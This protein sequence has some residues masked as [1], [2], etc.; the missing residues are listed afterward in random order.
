MSPRHEVDARTKLG[1]LRFLAVDNATLQATADEMAIPYQTVFDIASGYG[2]PEVDRMLRA[3]DHLQTV[4]DGHNDIPTPK[5][6]APR[7]DLSVARQPAP[8]ALAPPPVAPRVA[9]TSASVTELL[10]Q[11]F[12]SDHTRT[13]NL[14]TKISGLL[15]DLTARL[16]DETAER[17]AKTAAAAEKA[18]NAK[19]IAELEAEL[20]RLKGKPAPAAKG[21]HTTPAAGR[22]DSAQI[23]VWATANSVDCPAVGRVPNRVRE[24]YDNAHPA[25]QSA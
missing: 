10:H 17:Q 12:E 23:R 9:S 11:A 5:G 4:A 25:A 1:V 16:H 14:G 6:S 2:Y 18:K 22:S 3:I 24:A 13:R 8:P 15:A 7:P 20:A 21:G 19:R